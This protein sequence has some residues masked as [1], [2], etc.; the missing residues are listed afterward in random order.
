MPLFV[1]ESRAI[2]RPR[3]DGRGGGAL[4]RTTAGSIAWRNV[5]AP[6]ATCRL[7]AA[8]R[9]SQARRGSQPTQD[10]GLHP[11][12]PAGSAPPAH[13]RPLGRAR[14]YVGG[15]P[16][17]RM[18]AFGLPMA[19]R[20]PRMTRAHDR[21]NTL[22][23]RR[24]TSCTNERRCLASAS[25]SLRA[26]ICRHSVRALSSATSRLVSPRGGTSSGRRA[27]P[28]GEVKTRNEEV[29]LVRW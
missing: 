7:A 27:K 4:T 9:R 17:L 12:G 26:P 19:G 11:R 24:C 15:G 1:D 28:R 14:T 16:W 8:A 23:Q 18:S 22:P 10:A 5:A 21:Q 3:R 20:R 25:C 29:V 2:G 13:P 6:R